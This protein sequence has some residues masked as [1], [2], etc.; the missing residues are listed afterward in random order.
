MRT[1]M[2]STSTKGICTRICWCYKN[3][4]DKFCA[5]IRS[6]ASIPLLAEIFGICIVLVLYLVKKAVRRVVE[7]QS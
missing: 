6:I 4:V 3:Y 2:P 1:K 5:T 7:A